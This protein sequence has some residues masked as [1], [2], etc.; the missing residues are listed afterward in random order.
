M[1]G[2]FDGAVSLPE[3]GSLRTRSIVP[4]RATGG[5]DARR[6]EVAGSPAIACSLALVAFP[7]L[8]AIGSVAAME[9]D[10]RVLRTELMRWPCI[11]RPGFHACGIPA[12]VPDRGLTGLLAKQQ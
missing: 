9:K 2:A 4:V 8:S 3:S 1:V 7:P 5:L 12:S 6:S 11:A 10:A